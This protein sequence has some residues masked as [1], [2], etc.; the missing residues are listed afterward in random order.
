[1]SE[2]VIVDYGMGNL[3]S[4][5]N[6]LR[7]IGVEAEISADPRRVESA[8]GVIV[9]GV[10]AF[11]DCM[12][13]LRGQGL[14]APIRR[15]I[16]SDRPVLGICLGLQVLFDGSDESPDVSGLGVFSGRVV[17]FPPLDRGGPRKVPHMGWN[18]IEELAPHPLLAGVDEGSY[19]YFVHSYFVRPN[20][21]IAAATT[22]YGP[23]FV[24]AVARGNLFACQF[25]PEK[26]QSVGLRMLRNFVDLVRRNAAVEV[27]R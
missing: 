26:S 10:G 6:A 5:A 11:G 7:H 3:G 15:A 20:E 19:V 21:A 16:D 13:R 18:A 17:G 12:T 25:H 1:M 2:I 4:V 22:T 8:T 24:S 27:A 9:P 23:R 14:A